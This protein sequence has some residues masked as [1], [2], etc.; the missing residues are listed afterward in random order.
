MKTR[1]LPIRIGA[2]CREGFSKTFG[3]GLAGRGL[4][5]VDTR[6]ILAFPT[7]DSIKGG[8]ILETKGLCR[9]SIGDFG[10]GAI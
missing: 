5:G 7:F 9:K 2:L 4:F 3:L 6:S 8:A 1:L 10:G